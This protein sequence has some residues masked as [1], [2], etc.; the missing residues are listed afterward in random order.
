[1]TKKIYK[2]QLLDGRELANKIKTD[3]AKSIFKLE[4][5]PGLA[6]ILVGDNEASATYIK[7]K[8]KACLEVGIV[9]H[10]YL[11]PDNIGEKDLL[12]LIDFLNK[13]NEVDGILLQLPLPEMYPTQKIINAISP[14]KDVDGFFSI[15]KNG[16]VIPP[17][18]AAICELLKAIPEELKDK[19]TLV[20]AKSEVYTGKMD[21]YLSSVGLTNIKTD[22]KIPK[23]SMDYDVIIIALGQAKALKKEM[24]K[25]GVIVIDVGI[26]K[27]KDKLVGDVDDDVKDVAS[28]ISPVP[29]GVGPLTVA[30]LLRN[31]LELKIKHSK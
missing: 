30:C 5:K 10:S 1:M 31:T 16:Q 24:V 2:A 22:S 26:N 8:E 23:K 18:M 17:T 12:E 19:K 14:S 4:T 7:L 3:L 6:A 13:D 20:V 27:I 28:F 15:G 21:K 9:F 11:C 29:G 25:D